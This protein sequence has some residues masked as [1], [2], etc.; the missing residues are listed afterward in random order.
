MTSATV[1]IWRDCGFT[2]GT[3]EVPSK[4]SSLPSYQYSFTLPAV[5]REDLFNSFRIKH[6][7]EDLY[8]CNYL[9]V[10][11]DMNN[12]DD[13][14]V[15]GWIDA[16]RCISD[17]A[18][19]PN[20]LIEW[21]TDLWRTFLSKATFGAGVVTKRPSSGTVPPQTYSNMTQLAIGPTTAILPSTAGTY[22]WA[23]INI[24]VS[25]SSTGIT[26]FQ[27]RAWPVNPNYPSNRLT[28][29]YGSTTAVTPSYY[30]TVQGSFDETIGIDPDSI[31]AAWI[32]PIAPA[33]WG[34][35]S[36][37]ITMANWRVATRTVSS[38]T[39][40]TFYP[41][42]SI[43]E[44]Q[45][46]SEYIQSF[47]AKTTD[48][49]TYVVCDMDN[50][51]VF[52]LPWGVTVTSAYS[53]I[54]NADVSA[55]ISIRFTTSD[56]DVE[57]SGASGLTCNIPLKSLGVSS[58]ARSSYIYSGQQEYDRESMSIARDQALVSS[59]TSTL[60][61]TTNN[62]VMSSLGNT[63]SNASGTRQLKGFNK[64]NRGNYVAEYGKFAPNITS[65]ASSLSVG[66]ASLLTAG[67]GVAGAAIDYFATGYFNDRTMDATMDYKSA[68]TST[69][70]LPSSGTDFIAYGNV[71]VIRMLQWDSYSMV[72]RQSDISLYGI[73]VREPMTSCQ[74]LINQ[75]GPIRIQ[76]LNVTG[77][78]PPGAKHFFRERFAQGVRMI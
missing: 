47:S 49:D 75:G 42:P 14:T 28:I 60:T 77:G 37:V 74:A 31:Y 59:L 30:E 10:T 15:Y 23:I 40:G 16:V 17:T 48:T 21:H 73:S 78:I 51:P 33:S 46:Y 76:N 19:S 3:L 72:Q 2:E 63:T 13:V 6:A 70:T 68:Q 38:T 53:R 56:M 36:G 54:V 71:P 65:S 52:Q 18:G 61:G 57:E 9:Q 27:T 32:S 39:Y 22:W 5:P 11:Y 34:S 29:K 1:R 69:L 26:Y 24:T 67:A 25:D 7:Y 4:T 41:D 64:D 20:T 8:D 62:A 12:G 50:T 58:N 43:S 66:K 35:S 45:Y 55:Y 44:S